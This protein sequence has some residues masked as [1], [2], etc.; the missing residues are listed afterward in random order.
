MGRLQLIDQTAVL[1]SGKRLLMHSDIVDSVIEHEEVVD[2]WLRIRPLLD[3]SN[4]IDKIAAHLDP[5]LR[6]GLTG[7]LDILLTLRLIRRFDEDHTLSDFE[8]TASSSADVCVGFGEATS[9]DVTRASTIWLVGI[10]SAL[11]GLIDRAVAVGLFD[12]VIIERFETLPLPSINGR[13]ENAKDLG[14]HPGLANHSFSLEVFESVNT[15]KIQD[16][17]ESHTPRLI[18][19]EWPESALAANLALANLAHKRSVPILYGGSRGTELQVGPLVVPGETACWNCFRLRKIANEEHVP[20]AFERQQ[21]LFEQ[22]PWP[23]DQGV[24]RLGDSLGALL[25][26]LAARFLS[27]TC[28]DLTKGRVSFIN[29]PEFVCEH[30]I[31]VP[32]SACSVCG[33][34]GAGAG[35]RERR[36]STMPD[37][38]RLTS[39]QSTTE[40]LN[41]ILE[42]IRTWIGPKIGIIKSIDV[43]PTAV[44][45]V[46][47][48]PWTAA[49]AVTAV[50]SEWHQIN[51]AGW[52][53]GKGVTQSDALLGAIGEALERYSAADVRLSNLKLCSMQNL[54]GDFIDPRSLGLYTDQQLSSPSFPYIRFDPEAQHHWVLGRWLDSLEPVWMPALPVFYAPGIFAG[55]SYCQVTSNG[56]AGG[57]SWQDAALRATL[58][59]VERHALMVTWIRRLAGTP[60]LGSGL[61]RVSAEIVGVLE[62]MGA[63]VELYH[64]DSGLDIP[65]VA[66]LAIGNGKSWPGLTLS[67]AADLDLASAVRKA[68]LEQGLVGP[69]FRDAMLKGKA[70]RVQSPE[71]VQSFNDH[72][73]YYIHS[74]NVVN[75]DFLRFSTLKPLPIDS[76]NPCPSDENELLRK[77]AKARCRVAIADV[78]SGD[79]SRTPFKVVRALAPSLQPMYCGFGLERL[80]GDVNQ[81][82]SCPDYSPEHYIHPMS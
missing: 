40:I 11:R 64:L 45:D 80:L 66:C 38:E 82:L 35:S 41:R 75:L 50:V 30:H 57:L 72:A 42:S 22:Q 68:A 29:V 32:H 47:R 52:G 7:L 28:D 20:L 18:I 1:T 13:P 2:L 65:C 76:P 63:S 37:G 26:A 79:V 10:G 31:V 9:P 60:I 43:S 61:D 56:L 59:L 25:A 23:D 19:C 77:L 54:V 51:P 58:E 16:L 73:L 14:I 6:A 53:W 74:R 5:A 3:G 78:T 49:V 12:I 46:V 24:E 15:P 33:S 39:E 4:D 69:S 48:L 70:A 34:V 67:C 44:G 21:V 81:V 71:Q 8:R 62:E 27:G 55:D 17:L 36:A